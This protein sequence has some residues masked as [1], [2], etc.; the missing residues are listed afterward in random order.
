MKTKSIKIA[1]IAIGSI[2]SVAVVCLAGVVGSDSF[3]SFANFTDGRGENNTLTINSTSY[4]V[5]QSYSDGVFEVNTPY[6]NS[7][8]FE[9][10]QGKSNDNG[11][12]TLNK[13]YVGNSLPDYCY[14]GND[15]PITSV[16]SI[17]VD[18]TGGTLTLFAS[19]NNTDFFKVDVFTSS[20][21]T[22]L[23]NNYLYFRFA[24]GNHTE[25]PL[26][27]NS[28]VFSYQCVLDDDS[29]EA[30][31]MSNNFTLNGAAAVAGGV[32][33][34][35]SVYSDTYNS[36][37]SIKFTSPVSDGETTYVMGDSTAHRWQF[38]WHL[39][40]K[41]LGSDLHN[42]KL[43]ML[44]NSELTSKG[45]SK[46]VELR[47]YPSTKYWTYQD[48]GA[49]VRVYPSAGKTGWYELTVDFSSSST[50]L[51][52]DSLKDIE[53][54]YLFV[55]PNHVAPVGEA[56]EGY[57]YVDELR[58]EYIQNYPAFDSSEID[59]STEE[60]DDISNNAFVSGYDSADND[61]NYVN[62]SQNSYR[63]RAI[64]PS[65]DTCRFHFDGFLV[66]ME[67]K[68][69]SFDVKLQP[70]NA[71]M[72]VAF[73]HKDNGTDYRYEV[74]A[75]YGTE[76]GVTIVSYDGDYAGWKHYEIDFDTA[77]S[78]ATKSAKPSTS[79][80]NFGFI[81]AHSTNTVAYLDNIYIADK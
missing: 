58:L 5:S 23:G 25:T 70:S 60:K 42:M 9:Y 26:N 65:A 28:I 75:R 73:Y 35:T 10:K 24:N 52:S 46:T 63:S 31:D 61:L 6:G 51:N 77:M 69:I 78:S 30:S 29:S 72:K 57:L 80:S 68:T 13:N 20:G 55:R 53:F 12:I 45:D 38:G 32:A 41:I 8:A 7:V 74:T 48:S 71:Y 19:N 54:E 40:R 33:A 36:R 3:L 2:F 17:S 14:V 37:Q 62:R 15:D 34:D 76:S 64:T 79:P 56:S 44:V 4:V 67:G 16:S 39:P 49:C 47:I 66:D 43:N 81:I 59:A 27:L 11:L 18:Y 50:K 1:A 21:T 22:V